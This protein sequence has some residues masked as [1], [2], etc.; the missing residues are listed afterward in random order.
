[1]KKILK[2]L[3]KLSILFLIALFIE[4]IISSGSIMETNP[5]DWKPII[6]VFQVAVLLI[7]LWA[8]SEEWKLGDLP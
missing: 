7:I 4:I 3:S 8:S 6:Y 5:L 1:M 2:F